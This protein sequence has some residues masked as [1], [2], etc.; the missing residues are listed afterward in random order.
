MAVCNKLP[1]NSRLRFV[2]AAH[3][4]VRVIFG[5]VSVF[6][7]RGASS[8]LPHGSTAERLLYAMALKSRWE[9]LVDKFDYST[10]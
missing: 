2:I 7:L 9:H 5:E 10:L 8:F 6:L 1:G 4:G 3:V